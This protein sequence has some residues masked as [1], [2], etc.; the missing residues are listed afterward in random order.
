LGLVAAFFES[1]HHR[2]RGSERVWRHIY[3]TP[4]SFKVLQP[5]P[6][7]PAPLLDQQ[8]AQFL[9]RQFFGR[10]TSGH[11]EAIIPPLAKILM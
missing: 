2:G 4:C 5:F 6:S 9:D 10:F 8:A 1:I 3:N 11:G 7:R